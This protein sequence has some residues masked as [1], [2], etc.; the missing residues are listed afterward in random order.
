VGA[1]HGTYEEMKAI[2]LAR[3]A[4]EWEAFGGQHRLPLAAVRKC[5]PA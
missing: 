3:S 2:F 4:D 5:P 1:K